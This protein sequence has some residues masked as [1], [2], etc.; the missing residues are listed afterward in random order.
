MGDISICMKEG[1]PLSMSAAHY[2]LP[3]DSAAVAARRWCDR[4][5][6]GMQGEEAR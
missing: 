3:F 2:R 5:P 1:Q 6:E 4:S